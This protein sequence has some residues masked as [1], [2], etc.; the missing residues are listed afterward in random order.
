MGRTHC[1]SL[2]VH[3][4]PDI[5]ESQIQN[6]LHYLPN[7]YIVLHFGLEA[8]LIR[9][10]FQTIYR[11]HPRVFINDNCLP[12]AW[13]WIFHA[14]L[15]NYF[16]AKK[17]GLEFGFFLMDSSNSLLFRH[18]LE[19][20]LDRIDA[21]YCLNPVELHAPSMKEHWVK[22][23]AFGNDPCF[24]TM[25]NDLRCSNP[26]YC[27]HEGTAFR[28]I[29]LDEMVSIITKHY[30]PRVDEIYYPREE[31]YWATTATHLSQNRGDIFA[32]TAD[33]TPQLVTDIRLQNMIAIREFGPWRDVNEEYFNSKF[34]IKPV[35]RKMDDPLRKHIT[36]I[37]L[38]D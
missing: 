31:V 35:P 14:Q 10:N 3:E 9:S 33:L 19:E 28:K 18:G 34:S 29:L 26:C 7:S 21:D 38:L 25:V 2:L 32:I 16:F 12:T 17:L 11:N 37:Q 6:A 1:L 15:S 20:Y 4:A 30:S 22:L 24:I 8:A 13:G 27:R 36:D 23:H 5:I